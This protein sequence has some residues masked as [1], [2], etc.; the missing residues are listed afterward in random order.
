ML[1][2]ELEDANKKKTEFETINEINFV[3]PIIYTENPKN[4]LFSILHEIV[5]FR[6]TFFHFFGK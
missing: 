5:L 4:I 1:F 3:I 6:L 2:C